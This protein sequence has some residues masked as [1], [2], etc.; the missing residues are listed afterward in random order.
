MRSRFAVIAVSA[1]T[2][3]QIL[4]VTISLAIQEV[5]AARIMG[6]EPSRPSEINGLAAVAAIESAM[7]DAISEAEQSVVSIARVEPSAFEDRPVLPFNR[8]DRNNPDSTD[9]IPVDFGS[10]VVIGVEGL[11]I[12]QV[13]GLVLTNLHVVRGGTR[14]RSEP[15]YQE[16][17]RIHVRLP[18]R[19]VCEGKI[20]A[21]DPRSDLA[22]IMIE[23]RD[24]KSSDLKPI[25]FADGAKLR[26][27]ALV[28]GL[29]NPYAA[30]RD[31]SASASWGIVSNVRR[32]P[33]HT[34][35]RTDSDV[36]TRETLHDLGDL[37]Q[38]DTRLN[39]G[40]SGGAL[41]NFRGELV[42]LTTSLAALAGYEKSA[43]YAVPMESATLRII[44]SLKEGKEAEYG[45]LGV[46]FGN[47]DPFASRPISPN[48]PEG[49][50][51]IAVL[52]GGPAA[53]AG[54]MPH[55]LI[56]NVNGER[57]FTRE[58]LTREINKLAPESPA[59]ISVWR[60]TGLGVSNTTL[61][62]N[63]AKWGAVDE[64]EIIFTNYRYPPWR[65]LVIDYSTARLKHNGEFER[66][67]FPQGVLISRLLPPLDTNPHD[68]VEGNRIV[69]V[70]QQTVDTPNEFLNVVRD[71]KGDVTL[72][73]DNG[74]KVV[75]KE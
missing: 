33:A 50:Q 21:A 13:R 72:H 37:I 22:V 23:A 17:C 4:I 42:G 38:V 6:Q 66:R 54:V 12:N 59:R 28:I 63:L 27:G 56:L 51:V 43:G 29:G 64:D 19:R 32:R 68:L 34:R 16:T 55:D 25:R 46:V 14:V 48:V 2:V 75:M 5:V 3:R 74:K 26:K 30:A 31:G 60:S 20:Y 71:L 67:D 45:F 8:P 65:G 9:F 73:L 44:Q 15:N 52:P 11:A 39:L 61:L 18:N 70:N 69:Q 1:C 7:V 41:V 62:V 49:V 53:R 10:G 47:N 58:D 57:V 24:L 40:T 35:D 36:Q